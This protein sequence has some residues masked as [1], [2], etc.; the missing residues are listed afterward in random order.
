[1]YKMHQCILMNHPGVLYMYLMDYAGSSLSLL[2]IVM[3]FLKFSLSVL[4]RNRCSL[5]VRYWFL[6]TNGQNFE[7]NSAC[8]LK[9][10][11]GFSRTH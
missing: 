7:Y 10:Q 2:N 9:R 1:M 3:L 8:E 5:V 6:K 11:F 4:F